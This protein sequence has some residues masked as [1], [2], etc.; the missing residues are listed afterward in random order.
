[1]PLTTEQA[2]AFKTDVEAD[3]VLNALPP[4]A[5]SAFA[6]ADAY[7]LAASPA[8]I[9]WRTSVQLDEI[10]QNGFDWTRV[11]NLNVGN[12]RIW[13]WL[14]DNEARIIN[15][16]RPNVRAGIEEC[17]K[18]TAAD[19]AVRAAVYTHCKRAA[20]RLERLFATGT[21]SDA[22]P[23]TMVIEGGLNYLDVMTAMG[24]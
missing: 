17:W 10:M 2:A 8:F 9:V 15:P 18:G 1:M 12:A 22:S 20:N 14:F 24:W 6:I 23:G 4:S 21:G 3:Q 16:S 13:E 19:L 11:N 5:D 7:R